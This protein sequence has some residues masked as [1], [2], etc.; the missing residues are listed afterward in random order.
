MVRLRYVG[1][2]KILFESKVPFIVR[3]YQERGM[4]V[5]VYR[6]RLEIEV[7]RRVEWLGRPFPDQDLWVEVR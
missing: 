4:K 3:M 5:R 7:P 2:V 6:D 1:E